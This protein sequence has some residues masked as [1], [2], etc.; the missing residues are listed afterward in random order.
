MAILLP[1]GVLYTE[2]KNIFPRISMSFFT[3]FLRK[4]IDFPWSLSTAGTLALHYHLHMVLGFHIQTQMG[5]SH[6]DA[7]SFNDLFL[8][9][10]TFNDLIL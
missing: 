3:H 4:C 8:Y 9:T 7:M 2:I 6:L 5:I 10:M 1:L